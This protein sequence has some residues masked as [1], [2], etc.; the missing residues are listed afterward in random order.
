MSHSA[1]LLI[2]LAFCC[3]TC[4]GHT[5]F[6]CFVDVWACVPHGR[7]IVNCEV[8]V[9]QSRRPHFFETWSRRIRCAVT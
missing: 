8:F 6:D 4:E 2:I 7:L 9:C 3:P 5:S 1:E